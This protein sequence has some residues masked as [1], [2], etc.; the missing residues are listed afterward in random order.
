[1]SRLTEQQGEDLCLM[2][3]IPDDRRHR[4]VRAVERCVAVYRR[5]CDYKSAPAVGAELAHVEKC[6]WRA[7]RLVDRKTWRRSEFH[8][9]LYD[10]SARLRNLSPAARDY[11]KFRNLTIRQ[12]VVLSA[13]PNSIGTD[14]LIDPICF[15]NRDDQVLALRD[16]LG[17]FAG[18]VTR[19]NRPGRRYK[20]LERALYHFL[21]AAYSGATGRTASDTSTKFM[22]VCSEIKRIYQ[23]D[24][25][26]PQSLARSTRRPRTRER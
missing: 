5:L 15:T 8:T 13:W 26:S 22:I 16:L 24:D 10:I 2:G 17:A 19:K 6:L 3:S 14:V 1:M 21:A 4:F 20:D 18:P 9:V 23:L 11:L 25:W 12:D 7:L